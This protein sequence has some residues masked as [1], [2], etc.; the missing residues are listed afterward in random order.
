MFCEFL[1]PEFIQFLALDKIYIVQI[2]QSRVDSPPQL[3]VFITLMLVANT[4]LLLTA[5][6][7]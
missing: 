6:D 3:V 4:W 5:T 1:L 7:Y 2:A